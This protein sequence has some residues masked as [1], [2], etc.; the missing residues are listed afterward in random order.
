[1]RR[2]GSLGTGSAQQVPLVME[3]LTGHMGWKYLRT[4]AEARPNDLSAGLENDWSLSPWVCF[5]GV[6]IGLVRHEPSATSK[7]PPGG[8]RACLG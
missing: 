3:T 5:L 1:M 8:H 7:T 4:G 6:G 2:P